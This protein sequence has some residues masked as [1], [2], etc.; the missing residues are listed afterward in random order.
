MANAPQPSGPARK[1]ESRGQHDC[2]CFALIVA[3][4][5]APPP[6]QR[7]RNDYIGAQ[8][9]QTS[10]GIFSPQPAHQLRQCFTVSMFHAQDNFPKQAIVGTES[11]SFLKP[12]IAISTMG[13]AVDYGGMRS[14]AGGAPRA[15]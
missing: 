7:N 2:Q 12:E 4:P 11:A 9:P 8:I 10:F 5:P 1:L 14:H 3:A 15:R 13:A 6:M